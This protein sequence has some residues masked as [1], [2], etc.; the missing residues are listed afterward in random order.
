VCRGSEW[1]CVEEATSTRLAHRHLIY[2]DF[3]A[4]HLMY[5]RSFPSISRAARGSLPICLGRG[6][7]PP[8]LDACIFLVFDPVTET[9]TLDACI[10]DS[11]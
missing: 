10:V 2:L 7:Q 5:E 4:G 6:E 1:W 3:M 11:Y 8:P 9:L